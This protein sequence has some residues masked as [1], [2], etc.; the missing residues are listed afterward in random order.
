MGVQ[1][2]NLPWQPVGSDTRVTAFRAVGYLC[3]HCIVALHQESATVLEHHKQDGTEPEVKRS[4]GGDLSGVAG[5]ISWYVAAKDVAGTETNGAGCMMCGDDCT[6][7]SVPGV[8]THGHLV[9]MH[10]RT[11]PTKSPILG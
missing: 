2:K 6:V 10:I 11:Q 7:H 5:G 8:N 4:E 1:F 3:T 9:T